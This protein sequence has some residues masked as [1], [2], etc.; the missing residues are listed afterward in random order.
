[1]IEVAQIHQLFSSLKGL[2]GKAG[3]PMKIVAIFLGESIYVQCLLEFCGIGANRVSDERIGW[4][5]R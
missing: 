3:I 4:Q 2:A 1:M 5:R